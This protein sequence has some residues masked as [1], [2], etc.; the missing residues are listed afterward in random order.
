MLKIFSLYITYETIVRKMLL[1]C[2]LN[3][4]RSP[5]SEVVSSFYLLPSSFSG[6]G[7]LCNTFIFLHICT[8]N[9]SGIALRSCKAEQMK[10]LKIFDS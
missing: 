5:K 7:Q 3:G 2:S 4:I 6:F 1:Y 10:S 8:S 9:A